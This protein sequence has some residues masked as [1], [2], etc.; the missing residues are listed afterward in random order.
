MSLTFLC[1]S[2]RRRNSS[3]IPAMHSICVSMQRLAMSSPRAGLAR[4]SGCSGAHCVC[5]LLGYHG[6]DGMQKV[7][8]VG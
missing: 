4:L 8:K 6:W 1:S 7:K 5:A 3:T 2:S